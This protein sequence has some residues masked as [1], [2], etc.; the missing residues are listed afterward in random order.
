MKINVNKMIL[1]GKW[2]DD[3]GSCFKPI[4]FKKIYYNILGKFAVIIIS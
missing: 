2:C 4:Y 3:T 1:D